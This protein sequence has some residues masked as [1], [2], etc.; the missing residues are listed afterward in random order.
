MS[1]RIL[2]AMSAEDLRVRAIQMSSQFSKAVL[3]PIPGL[4][5]VIIIDKSGT[6]TVIKLGGN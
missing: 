6:P 1:L 2:V 5:Q 3:Y 4:K